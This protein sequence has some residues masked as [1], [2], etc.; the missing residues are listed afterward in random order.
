M[1]EEWK[2][3]VKWDGRYMVSNLGRLARII[4]KPQRTG[5]CFTRVMVKGEW[6]N[7]CLHRIV[8]ENFLGEIPPDHVVHHI[9]GD[10][11]NNHV[12]NLQV[13]HKDEHAQLPARVH[14]LTDDNLRFIRAAHRPGRGPRKRSDT[15]PTVLELAE[16]FGVSAMTITDAQNMGEFRR[17]AK[18]RKRLKKLQLLASGE[19]TPQS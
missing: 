8:A 13:M 7:M 3:L 18:E 9:D 4:A 5:Y 19:V 15:R 11:G 1:Q 14:K 17:R 2:D 12:E 10:P 16:M 6:V